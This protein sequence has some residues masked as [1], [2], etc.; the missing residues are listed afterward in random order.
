M[1]PQLLNRATER[2]PLQDD[3]DDAGNVAIG[4]ASSLPA[5]PTPVQ[6][7]VPKRAKVRTRTNLSAP[8]KTSLVHQPWHCICVM[9]FCRH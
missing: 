1:R 9:A 4:A 3:E 6:R 2:A 8:P 5:A 7:S